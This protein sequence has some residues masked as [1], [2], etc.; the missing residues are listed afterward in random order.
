MLHRI[1]TQF[2]RRSKYQISASP[3]AEAIL[4]RVRMSQLVK[5]PMTTLQPGL[6]SSRPDEF[7]D[8]STG[9]GANA[10]PLVTSAME[11][12]RIS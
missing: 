2:R 9:N 5:A 3:H 7:S 12:L 10:W 4:P 11:E 6:N 8:I 1:Y